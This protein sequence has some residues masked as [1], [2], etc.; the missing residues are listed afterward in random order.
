MTVMTGRDFRRIR[1]TKA[2]EFFMTLRFTR[3]DENVTW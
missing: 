2:T 3:E 1:T